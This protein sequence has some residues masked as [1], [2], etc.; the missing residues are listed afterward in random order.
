[1]TF[2]LKL[3]IYGDQIITY[4]VS[5]LYLRNSIAILFET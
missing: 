5:F 3:P 4:I 2:S 1:M